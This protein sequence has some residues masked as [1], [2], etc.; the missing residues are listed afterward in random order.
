MAQYYQCVVQ[1]V[2]DLKRMYPTLNLDN[3]V[4][5]NEDGTQFGTQQVFIFGVVPCE[6]EEYIFVG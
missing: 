5:M 4:V 3:C 6:F 2:E 1:N